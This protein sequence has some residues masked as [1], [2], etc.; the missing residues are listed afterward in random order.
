VARA[1]RLSGNVSR[2]RKTQNAKLTTMS[3]DE[4]LAEALR[5]SREERARIAAD[6]L[7]SLDHAPKLLAVQ[8]LRVRVVN[9]SQPKDLLAT[10]TLSGFI[11]PGKA[12]T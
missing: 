11:L 3:T 2:I 9:I 8:D 4:L 6:L 1:A 5:L 12:R 7:S 10:L